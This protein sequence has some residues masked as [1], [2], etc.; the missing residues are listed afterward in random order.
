MSENRG[1]RLI[2]VL[3]RT[4]FFLR[5]MEDGQIEAREDI[6]VVADVRERHLENS[7]R[8]YRAKRPPYPYDTEENPR[9]QFMA[10][11]FDQ[12]FGHGGIV[13]VVSGC[14]GHFAF[15]AEQGSSA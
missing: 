6:E 1:V 14:L 8:F 3:R 4:A 2:E 7:A 9:A 12:A 13:P 15:H 5:V 10:E 11:G